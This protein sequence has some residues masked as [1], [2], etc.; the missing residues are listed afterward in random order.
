MYA[1]TAK[2]VIASFAAIVSA[3]GK[4]GFLEEEGDELELPGPLETAA[5]SPDMSVK[6]RSTSPASQPAS[7]RSQHGGHA[8]S[9][10]SSVSFQLCVQLKEAPPTNKK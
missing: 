5:A 4:R 8:S 3:D 9:Q 1:L 7:Q 10:Y 6:E 2:C